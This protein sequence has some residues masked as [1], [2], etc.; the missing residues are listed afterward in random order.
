MKL[1]CITDL[2]TSFG[3]VSKQYRV[4]ID[5]FQDLEVAPLSALQDGSGFWAKSLDLSA[6]IR[7]KMPLSL[8]PL[9]DVIA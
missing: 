2:P 6:G 1:G 8:F 5:L 7:D 9:L 4:R 3:R